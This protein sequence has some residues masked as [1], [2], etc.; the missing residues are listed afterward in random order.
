MSIPIH[1]FPSPYIMYVS[2]EIYDLQVT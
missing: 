1:L 2:F